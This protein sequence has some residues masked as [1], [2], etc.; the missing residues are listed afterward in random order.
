[1][2]NVLYF[3]LWIEYLMFCDG[4]RG[5]FGHSRVSQSW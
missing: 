1:M 4:E 3:T 5:L 2:E